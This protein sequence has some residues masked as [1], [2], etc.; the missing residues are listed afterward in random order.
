MGGGRKATI[1][2][3]KTWDIDRWL[4][5]MAGIAE[6]FAQQGEAAWR[7][8]RDP[9]DLA[10]RLHWEQL[11]RRIMQWAIESPALKTPLRP[12]HGR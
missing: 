5:R 2:P 10:F 4:Y 8:S 9:K 12:F 7:K 11:H 1:M 3:I 6:H